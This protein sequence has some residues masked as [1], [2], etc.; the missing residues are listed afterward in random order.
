MTS[1]LP[2]L[3]VRAAEALGRG[4]VIGAIRY[5]RAA[6][7]LDVVA[8]RNVIDAYRRGE[9][10]KLA[11]D[12]S[13]AAPSRPPMAPAAPIRSPVRPAR[14]QAPSG[15]ET[16]FPQAEEMHDALRF[17]DRAP[18]VGDRSPGEV[19]RDGALLRWVVVVALVAY[20]VYRLAGRVVHV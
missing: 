13:V 20:L 8:A 15:P 12:A 6:T 9:T 11:A 5:L 3:P 19:R 1:P 4:D 18:G 2:P 10:W 16:G 7:S 14:P 17:R